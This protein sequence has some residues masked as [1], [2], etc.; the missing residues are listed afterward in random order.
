MNLII[1]NMDKSTIELL[2]NEFETQLVRFNIDIKIYNKEDFDYKKAMI[3]ICILNL[4]SNIN[5]NQNINNKQINL[6]NK[7]NIELM[8]LIDINKLNFND[9]Y[10]LSLCSGMKYLN[11]LKDILIEIYN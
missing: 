5:K 7:Y 2:N 3:Y 4:L 8:E 11:E 1:I 6:L 10:Y 9:R